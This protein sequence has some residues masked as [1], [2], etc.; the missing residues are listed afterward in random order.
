MRKWSLRD[1]VQEEAVDWRLF[2]WDKAI[3]LTNFGKG[4]EQRDRQKGGSIS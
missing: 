2:E 3:E 4:L 1:S